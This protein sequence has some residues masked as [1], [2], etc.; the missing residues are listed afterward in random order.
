MYFVICT[1]SLSR[2]QAQMTGVPYEILSKST[3][4]ETA[5]NKQHMNGWFEKCYVKLVLV[6]GGLVR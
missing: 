1:E 3:G 2:N 5:R 4:R 6:S